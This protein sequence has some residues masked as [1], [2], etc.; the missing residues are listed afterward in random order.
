MVNT[1]LPIN[2]FSKEKKN[3]KKSK[4]K[5]KINLEKDKK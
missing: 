3:K 2:L 1:T 5:K 4:K